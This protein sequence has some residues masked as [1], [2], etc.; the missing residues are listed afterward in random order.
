MTHLLYAARGKPNIP[1]PPAPVLSNFCAASF[2]YQVWA[3]SRKIPSPTKYLSP[4]WRD[5]RGS[6]GC[7]RLRCP[8]CSPGLENPGSGPSAPHA[9]EAAGQPAAPTGCAALLKKRVNAPHH[10]HW[11]RV[12]GAP[13]GLWGNPGTRLVQLP[14]LS[15]E[16][17]AH[18]LRRPDFRCRARTPR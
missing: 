3:Q 1:H 12:C 9:A 4:L 14:R 15:C 13:G 7:T 16:I 11:Q 2:T 6:L 5:Q 18:L 8:L 17:L 10:T